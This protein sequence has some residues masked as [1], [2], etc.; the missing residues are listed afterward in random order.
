MICSSSNA[1][2]ARFRGGFTL[3]EL[4]AVIIIMA[5]LMVTV[6]PSIKGMT[7]GASLRGATMQVRTSL[8]AAR[9][10]AVSRRIDTSVLFPTA[11]QDA[12]KGFRAIAIY[13]T[14][15]VS[16]WSFFPPGVFFQVT[17]TTPPTSETK[18]NVVIK[19]TAVN[20]DCF[21]Y[22]RLGERANAAPGSVN[23]VQGWLNGTTVVTNKV[24]G[25][26]KISVNGVTGIVQVKSQ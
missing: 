18:S 7:Q 23:I 13:S 10:N 14:N 15:Y 4:L 8:I 6:V 16:D 11:T 5:I 26:T 20:V 25:A 1:R 12:D 19:T 24:G 17:K 3:A 21:T 22:T 2:R 9:Q